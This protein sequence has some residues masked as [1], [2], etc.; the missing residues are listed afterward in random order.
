MI[1][2]GDGS[3]CQLS[4][5]GDC[6]SHSIIYEIDISD[7]IKGSIIEDLSEG[8]WNEDSLSTET[9]DTESV[10]LEK[11]KQ[12]GI[13]FF[14]EENRI[15]NVVLKTNKGNA[16]IRHANSSNGYYDGYTNYKFI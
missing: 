4:I 1:E 6:C 10:A 2:F 14:P 5:D 3:K 8:G 13:E 7:D 15:W 11:I 9:A 16:L 12:S